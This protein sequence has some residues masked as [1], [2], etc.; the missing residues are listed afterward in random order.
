ML[1]IVSDVDGSADYSNQFTITGGSR[2]GG[3]PAATS[4]SAPPSPTSDPQLSTIQPI[5]QS[6]PSPIGTS[7]E[8]ATTGP[9]SVVTVTAIPSATAAADVGSSG[10]STGAKAGIG[11]G[12]PLG[13]FAILGILAAFLWRQRVR[14]R[15]RA[16]LRNE[17]GIW[18][19]VTEPGIEREESKL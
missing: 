17:P 12:V 10:L 7:T 18:H 13:V 11:V 16:A 1:A 2:G 6:S 3:A 5:S 9:P 19:S 14:A 15:Q 4:P 8:A